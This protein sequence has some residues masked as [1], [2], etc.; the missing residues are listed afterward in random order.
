MTKD[1]SEERGN[2]LKELDGFLHHERFQTCKFFT[3]IILEGVCK[4]LSLWIND[5]HSLK[6]KPLFCKVCDK[7]ASS[8]VLQHS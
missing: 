3:M 5:V 7:T 8:R 4:D 1:Y 6:L 2:L